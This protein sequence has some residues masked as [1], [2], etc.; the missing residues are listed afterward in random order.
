MNIPPWQ[1]SRLARLLH[2]NNVVLTE[3]LVAGIID[4]IF[5]AI[6]TQDPSP[7]MI[8]HEPWRTVGE[9][10]F[11]YLMGEEQEQ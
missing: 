8:C 7:K 9:K 3:E 6:H 1:Q 5:E 10:T 4:L 11:E 2:K